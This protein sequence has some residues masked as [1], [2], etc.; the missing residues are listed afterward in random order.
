MWPVQRPQINAGDAFATCIKGIQD[1]GLS[2]RLSSVRADIEAASA[3]YESKASA[4]DLHLIGTSKSVGGVVTKDEMVKLY[5][6]RMASKTGPGRAIYDQIRL[7]PAGDRCPFCDQRNVSTLDHILPKSLY[8]ALTVAPYNLVGSCVE[9]NKVK[10][11]TAPTTP[12]DNALHPYFDDISQ[13][14]WLEGRVVQQNPC[15]V[16]FRVA[17]PS[18][19]NAVM[20]ARVKAQFNML[21]LSSLYSSEAAREISNIRHNLQTHFDADGAQAVRAELL[22]QWRSRRANRLNSWQTATYNA[23]SHDTW[24]YSGG[25]A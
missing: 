13:Q 16:V 3:D 7:L 22:R 1:R 2:H 15:A 4:G 17:P 10:L 6:R 9:C 8:P 5:D 14:Q 11:A 19:W 23:L 24:F 12:E 25:F 18:A 21:G 20:I